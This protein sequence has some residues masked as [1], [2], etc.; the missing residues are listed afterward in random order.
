MHSIL[1]GLLILT[2]S[3]SIFYSCNKDKTSEVKEAPSKELESLGWLAGDWKDAEEGLDVTFSWR[4]ALNNHF[5]IQDYVMNDIDE[6]TLSGTQTLGWDPLEKTL[7]SWAF[8]SDGGFGE[9]RWN[10]S[11]GNWYVQTSYVTREG[12]KAS[13]TYVYRKIDNDTFNFSSEVREINGEILPDA[14][15]FKFV[16]RK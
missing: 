1:R 13:A 11:E 7:R 6:S 2:A 8:D 3:A 9:S 15:P 16:R 14:G 10:E 5:L 4:W 12:E